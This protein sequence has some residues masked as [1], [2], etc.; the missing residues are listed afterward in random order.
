MNEAIAVMSNL[1]ESTGNEL[2]DRILALIPDHPEILT[3]DSC[4]DLF[5]VSGFDCRDL[6]PSLAQ[7][8]WA[9]TSARCIWKEV[10]TEMQ[11]KPS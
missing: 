7:A 11:K 1:Y 10:G 4:W 9:L 3:L 6:Q 8:G 5:K 2:R